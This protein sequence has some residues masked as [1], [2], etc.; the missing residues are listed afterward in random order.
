VQSFNIND[1]LEAARAGDDEAISR[2]LVAPRADAN[3]FCSQQTTLLMEAACNGRVSTIELLVKQYNA[4]LES[5]NA[6]G[7]T[8]LHI[9]CD[10]SHYGAVETLLGLGA[11]INS[12]T[13]LGFTP[14]ECA[15][16]NDDAR[17]ARLLLKHG[18][19]VKTHRKYAETVLICVRGW[20]DW[21]KHSKA[22]ADLIAAFARAARRDEA[23]VLLEWQIAMAPLQLPICG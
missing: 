16:R 10:N 4:E 23:I 21:W 22:N 14:L 9:A 2:A 19:S 15:A 8:A 3:A 11:D 6:S 17:L 1:V 7:W 5:K 13:R 20:T 12:S 18:A